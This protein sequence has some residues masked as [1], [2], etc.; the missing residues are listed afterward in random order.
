[1][2]FLMRAISIHLLGILRTLFGTRIAPK[3]SKEN[4]M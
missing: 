3:W 2:Q 4:S 1:M